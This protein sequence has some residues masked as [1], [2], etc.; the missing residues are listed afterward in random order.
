MI[1]RDYISILLVAALFAGGLSA[2]SSDSV[3]DEPDTDA[4]NLFIGTWLVAGGSDVNGSVVQRLDTTYQLI[5]FTF[6]RPDNFQIIADSDNEN[7]LDGSAS[8]TFSS[9]NVTETIQLTVPG[10]GVVN[11]DYAFTGDEDLELIL[12]ANTTVVLNALLGTPFFGRLSLDL[13]LE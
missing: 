8:G 13:Q 7:V 11:A 2:C 4:N 10:S 1:V 6:T 5:S 3:P 9:N 12:D